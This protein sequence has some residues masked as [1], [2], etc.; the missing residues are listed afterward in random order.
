MQ[1]VDKM[2]DL[3]Q[4]SVVKS[5]VGPI[6]PPDRDGPERAEEQSDPTAT[7]KHAPCLQS[8]WGENSSYLRIQC[9]FIL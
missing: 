1:T 9:L 2:P 8:D 5:L 3:L 7:I 6:K 4:D